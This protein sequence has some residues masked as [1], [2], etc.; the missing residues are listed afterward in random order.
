MT[1]QTIIDV[2]P[3][4][5]EETTDPVTLELQKYAIQTGLEPTAQQTLA[6]AFRPVF[7]K[8]HEAIA[9]SQGVAESVKD[10]T[11]VTEIRKSRACRLQIRAVRIEGEKVHKAQKESALRFGKAVD[12]FKNI[13]LAEIVPIEEELQAAEDTAER[14]E[15]ARRRGSRLKRLRLR[16]LTM[17]SSRCSRTKYDCGNQY[18]LI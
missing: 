16:L 13:L 2:E 10:A 15:A 4:K 3:A 11:C 18:S 12:G 8:A 6:D 9:A 7:L 14:A 17:R 1:T 5:P